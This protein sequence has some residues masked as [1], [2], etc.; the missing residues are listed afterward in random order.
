MS[1]LE[2]WE[3]ISLWSILRFSWNCRLYSHS[4]GCLWMQSKETIIWSNGH[5]GN[6]IQ[7]LCGEISFLIWGEKRFPSPLL[8]VLKHLFLEHMILNYANLSSLRKEW[9]GRKHD[10]DSINHAKTHNTFHPTL[11]TGIEE[12]SK[13]H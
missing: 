4:M 13:M 11:T 7:E 5:V 9:E 10:K 3:K 2:R 12:V 8:N 1:S 6:V